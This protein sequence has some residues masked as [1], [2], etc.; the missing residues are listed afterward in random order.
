MT[1]TAR[2]DRQEEQGASP[3]P[4]SKEATSGERRGRVYVPLINVI[5]FTGLK[6]ATKTCNLVRWGV[7]ALG[8]WKRPVLSDFPFSYKWRDPITGEEHVFEPEPLPDDAFV[9]WLKDIPPYAILLYDEVQEAFDR[10]A[11]MT[12]ESRFGMS[13]FAQIRKKRVTII[14][15]TQFFH[16]LNPRL[17][18]QV[19]ILVR[20]QDMRM[21]PWGISENI[22]RGKEALSEYYD[23]SGAITGHSA[24]HPTNSRWISGEPYYEELVFTE[25]FWSAFDTLAVTNIQHRFTSYQVKK[26]KRVIPQPGDNSRQQASEELRDAL[27]NIF[28]NARAQGQTRVKAGDV[29]K[30][31]RA[32]GF[33]GANSVIGD[34]VAAMGVKKKE[35]RDGFHYLLEATGEQG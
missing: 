27:T 35:E 29:F 9:N 20:F 13:A 19:D 1:T 7:R 33:Q 22:E 31:L 10:Q 30:M 34:T 16:Y 28:E 32:D 25:P 18:D 8:V 4:L 24:R 3:L 17:N 6:G 5:V 21:T 2:L 12:V 14:G 23:L 26:E 11:W 15:A